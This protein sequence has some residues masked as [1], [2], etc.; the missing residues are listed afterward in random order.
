MIRNSADLSIVANLSDGR[1]YTAPV[2][3]PATGYLG[4]Y[5]FLEK[6]FLLKDIRSGAFVQ[7]QIASPSV[8]YY[9]ANHTLLSPAGYYLRLSR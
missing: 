5:S 1:D 4:G 6:A 2:I 9:L 7:K 8:A 3:D